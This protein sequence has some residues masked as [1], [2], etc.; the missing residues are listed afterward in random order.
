MS[1]SLT[2]GAPAFIS[3]IADKAVQST[4]NT[5]PTPARACGWSASRLDVARMLPDDNAGGTAEFGPHLFPLVVHH[6]SSLCDLV[7]RWQGA[8]PNAATKARLLPLLEGADL[9]QSERQP[10]PRT[11]FRARLCFLLGRES[12]AYR[13]QPARSPRTSDLHVVGIGEGRRAC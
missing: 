2:A 7:N 8:E 11:S 12:N 1:I 4:R 5:T 13:L 9:L 10:T 6:T 3:L